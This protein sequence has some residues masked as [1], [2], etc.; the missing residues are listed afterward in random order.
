M[1]NSNKYTYTALPFVCLFVL[2]FIMI[3]IPGCKT[4]KTNNTGNTI[5][6]ENTESSATE[7][8]TV[9][10]SESSATE[11]VTTEPT[12][13]STTEE[14]TTEPTESSTTVDNSNDPDSYVTYESNLPV[15][16]IN[17]EN[18]ADITSKTEYIN[19]TM[20]LQGNTLFSDIS[21]LYDGNIEIKGR[22]NSSWRNFKKKPYKIKLNESANLLGMGSN[23]HWVLIANYIDE[24]LMRNALAYRMAGNLGLTSMDSTW[25]DIVLN[26]K[27]I[28]NYVLCEQIRISEERV[29]IF[30][31]EKYGEKVASMVY[32]KAGLSDTSLELLTEKLTTDLSWITDGKFT[33]DGTE[34]IVS[35]YYN[36]DIDIKSGYLIELSA[37]Y[38][39]ITRFKT[40]ENAPILIQ[41]PT[42]LKTNKTMYK[43]VKGLIQAFEDA[44]YSED[45]YTDYNGKRVHYSELCNMDSLVNYWL[46]AETFYPADVIWKSRYM[47]I[48]GDG[49]ITFGPVWDYDYS[50]GGANPWMTI[51]YDEWRS[52]CTDTNNY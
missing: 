20:K 42:Y 3:N 9:H 15:L 27:Y 31:W 49:K 6:G 33:F 32:L 21:T 4:G 24:S 48:G 39:E 16:Y 47:Y 26:G 5:S 10:S 2:I 36:Q 46:V 11:E 13:S 52:S 1:K 22:G 34:Y 40:S 12:E 7:K 37:E 28:G 44:I 50:S 43:H 38:D 45:G 19:A 41:E 30:D 29:D 23:R 14:V 17:T 25:V 51:K 18:N 8:I 35:E